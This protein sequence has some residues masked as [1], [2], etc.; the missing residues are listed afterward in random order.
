AT[1][2]RRCCMSTFVMALALEVGVTVIVVVVLAGGVY[3][4]LGRGNPRQDEVDAEREQVAEQI[5]LHEPIDFEADL[6]P[7]REP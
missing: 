1:T 5:G 7:P 4:L 3:A 2:V 6:R